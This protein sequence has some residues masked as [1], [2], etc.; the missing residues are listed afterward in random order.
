MNSSAI[1]YFVNSA[2]AS[3]Y[4]TNIEYND[5]LLNLLKPRILYTSTAKRLIDSYKASIL[6]SNPTRALLMLFPP[7]SFASLMWLIVAAS[8]LNIEI[9]SEGEE[10][11]FFNF[12]SLL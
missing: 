11:F 10:E 9:L 4:I 3:R 6:I 1:K 7:N 8:D 2:F 5:V 12:E